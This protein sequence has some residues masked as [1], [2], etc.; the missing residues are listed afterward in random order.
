MEIHYNKNC[1]NK[2]ATSISEVAVLSKLM[3]FDLEKR[4]MKKSLTS[5]K[6]SVCQYNLSVFGI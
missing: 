6:N 5:Y 4:S 3:R 2:L 1:K